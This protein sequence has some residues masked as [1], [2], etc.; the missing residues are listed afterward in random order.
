MFQWEHAGTAQE[1]REQKNVNITDL[2]IIG[3]ATRKMSNAQDYTSSRGLIYL[4]TAMVCVSA[5]MTS[6]AHCNAQWDSAELYA[7]MVKYLN[8]QFLADSQD[9]HPATH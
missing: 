2:S 8:A 3:I 1:T 6:G 5:I 9:F 7:T 4:V